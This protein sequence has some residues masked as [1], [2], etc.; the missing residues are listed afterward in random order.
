[1]AVGAA[2]GG[3]G[4]TLL[5]R[6]HATDLLEEL[7]R[8]H[9]GHGSARV[10][11][12]VATDRKVAALTF[13]DGP[14]PRLTPR[15]LDMLRDH[16]VTATFFIIGSAAERHP[17]LLHRAIDE[18][19]EIGNHT[20]S[21][22]HMAYLG[23]AAAREEVLRGGQALERL[24]GKQARWFR[25]PRGMLTGTIVQA[26]TDLHQDVA[27]WTTGAPGDPLKLS[28]AQITDRLLEALRPGTI[29]DLHDG[30]SGRQHDHTF[31]RI[32][33]AELPA[34]PAFLEQAAA[35]GF[36]FLRLSDLVATEARA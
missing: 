34:Y 26:A 6:S 28:T 13:D 23:S 5:E 10:L 18:G 33:D 8:G 27:M 1:M 11:W 9:L 2:G 24:T 21:H 30:T 35:R 15:V 29:Y 14:H 32:R 36:T 7:D 19:H 12:S 16:H 3:V 25:S 22:P 17:D 4:G 20:W 31:E